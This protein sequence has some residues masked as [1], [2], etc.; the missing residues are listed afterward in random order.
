MHMLVLI[1]GSRGRLP[2]SD[3]SLDLL[4]KQRKRRVC[5]NLFYHY[6]QAGTLVSCGH[7]GPC[8]GGTG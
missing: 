2:T 8:I 4:Y 6:L 1:V 5:E 7:E 3:D